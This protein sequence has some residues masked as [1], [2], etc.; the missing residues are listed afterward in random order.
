M[1]ILS[2]NTFLLASVASCA[3][4][5]IAAQSLS[6][7]LNYNFNGIVHAGE[8]A[9]PDDP[10]GFRSISDRA[11]D[12]SAGVPADDLL[13]AYTIIDQPGVLDIVHIGNRNLTDSGNF[14]FDLAPDGDDIGIQPNWLT[15]LDQ[16]FV[17]ND[18]TTTP[19][20]VLDDTLFRILFQISNGGGSFDITFRFAGGASTTETVAGPDWFGG[21]YLGTGSVDSAVADNNLSLTERTI[22]LSAFSGDAIIGIDFGNRTNTNA[23]YAV[24][25]ARI[26]FNTRLSAPINIPLN[27]NYNGI[28]HAGETGLPDDPL[29]FRSISDRALDFTAGVPSSSTLDQYSLVDTAGTNDIVYLGSR[30]L[31]DG[32][33]WAFDAAADGDN[34]GIQPNWLPAVDQTGPQTTVLTNPIALDGNSRASVL[35]Q[36]SNGGGAMDITFTFQTAAPFT[37]TVAASDWFG[38]AFAGFANVDDPVADANL[39][40][41]ER[42]VDLSAFAGDFL[43]QITFSN[44]SNLNAGY[45]ILA[46]N[47]TGCDVPGSVVTTTGGNGATITSSSTGAIGTNINLEIT[48]SVPNGPGLLFFSIRP[49]TIP[50]S[51]LFPACSGALVA[52]N[53]IVIFPANLD[54]AGALSFNFAGPNTAALC[55]VTALFQHIG[56]TTAACPLVATDGVEYTFGF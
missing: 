10:N 36:V 43:T 8:V 1:R 31:T 25:A 24:L 46:A 23:G 30:N 39:T 29:G 48:N 17:T 37:A 52:P 12:F 20:P 18:L 13:A 5:P 41:D 42:E 44:Q 22:D 35:F 9:L 3:A 19:L 34:I 11:L 56:I 6:V 27:Y 49:G 53:Q 21:V 33:N 2:R 38:G 45:A 47:V 40:I 14:T 16:T 4:T 54:A 55:G 28:V 51:L 7:P 26:D 15:N 50:F 32:G